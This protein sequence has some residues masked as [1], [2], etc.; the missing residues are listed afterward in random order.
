MI[1][2][3]PVLCRGVPVFT[4]S[5]NYRNSTHSISVRGVTM[6]TKARGL[7]R[8]VL[9]EAYFGQWEVWFYPVDVEERG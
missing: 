7:I 4:A 6:A 2:G 8:V 1:P 5:T 3:T 9:D